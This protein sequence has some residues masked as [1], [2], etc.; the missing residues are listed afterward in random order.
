VLPADFASLS[1]PQQALILTNS[2]RVLYGLAPM[3]GLTSQL[4]RDAAA[5]LASDT[6][7]AP[8]T[9][10]W[11]GYTSNAAWG[12]AN[13]VV[14]Y[15]GW[16]YDD[17]PGSGNVDCTAVNPSGCW[18]HRHDILSQF[19]SGALAMGAAS[20]TDASGNPS[21]TMLLMEGSPTFHPVFTY[22][23]A[24]AQADGAGGGTGAATSAP[25]GDQPPAASVAMGAPRRIR[26]ESLRVR[27][28][29]LILRLAGPAG[30]KSSCSLSRTRGRVWRSKVCAHSVAFGHLPV[31]S[32]RL[33]VNSSAGE[34]TR[35]VVVR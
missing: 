18:G 3:T 30:T 23:W 28:H 24:Q 29:R 15:Q 19:G 8:S 17:G 10:N 35:H 21:Y 5:A 4:N 16:M 11:V 33:R 13:M 34:V 25:A 31:G 20:G 27:G 6:D 26:I 32:Y 22:T 12:Q 1:P 7:P 9:S 14:A 2:D